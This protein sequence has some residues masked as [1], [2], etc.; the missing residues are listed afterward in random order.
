MRNYRGSRSE[1]R[2]ASSVARARQCEGVGFKLERSEMKNG[3]LKQLKIQASAA[4]DVFLW[5]TLKVQQ[6]IVASEFLRQE[7]N[8]A[9]LLVGRRDDLF[10]RSRLWG[11]TSSHP[12]GASVMQPFK[13]CVD[14][15]LTLPAAHNNR[16]FSRQCVSC[17]K[18]FCQAPVC[19]RKS[20][21]AESMH[22]KSPNPGVPVQSASRSQTGHL[23]LL[24]PNFILIIVVCQPFV[25]PAE[26]TG[27]MMFKASLEENRKHHYTIMA[28]LG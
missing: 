1:R 15:W 12:A 23:R 6:E 26:V 25:S 2:S 24:V 16:R 10:L 13:S 28:E 9:T 27:S 3:A 20:C 17:T 7:V 4:F 21:L 22:Y 18:A 8:L 11:F 14:R 5:N 19:S